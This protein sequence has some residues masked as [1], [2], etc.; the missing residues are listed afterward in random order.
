MTARF[1]ET[2]GVTGPFKAEL[3]AAT[4]RLERFAAWG[5]DIEEVEEE[6]HLQQ[7]VNS[8]FKI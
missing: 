6:G 4:W 7:P 8:I 5:L 2:S 1:A 3:M